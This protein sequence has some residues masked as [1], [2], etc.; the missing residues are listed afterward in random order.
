M[1]E[2]RMAVIIVLIIEKNR[3]R[4]VSIVSQGSSI[5]FSFWKC[6]LVREPRHYL[7]CREFSFWKCILVR[8]PRHYFQCK[9]NLFW[10]VSRW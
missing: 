2:V 7:L 3:L 10:S 5:N 9:E 1:V 4:E 6:I 8:E